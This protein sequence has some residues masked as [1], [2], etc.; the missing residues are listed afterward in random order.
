MTSRQYN[1]DLIA[2]IEARESTTDSNEPSSIQVPLPH[3]HPS[4]QHSFQDEWKIIDEQIKEFERAHNLSASK[5][6]NLEYRQTMSGA[7]PLPGEIHA[8]AVPI[9]SLAHGEQIRGIIEGV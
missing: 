1:Q 5:P 2:A 3:L 4:Q 7:C 8:S 6:E 9:E